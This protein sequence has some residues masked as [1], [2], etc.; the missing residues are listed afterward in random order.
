MLTGLTKLR[1]SDNE[2][3]VIPPEI[4]SL[5]NLRHL[6]LDRNKVCKAASVSAKV[7]VNCEFGF[8]TSVYIYLFFKDW[9]TPNS[10]K[11]CS[12]TISA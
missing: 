8:S 4:A 1:L 9:P 3:G 12:N 11:L 7:R 2:I 5:E 10:L 6:V